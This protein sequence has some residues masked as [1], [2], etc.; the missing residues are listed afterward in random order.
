ML[1]IGMELNSAIT[2]AQIIAVVIIEIAF[3]EDVGGPL[4]ITE[5][6]RDIIVDGKTYVS[7]AILKKLT[8]PQ[9]QNSVDR[10]NYKISFNDETHVL[11]DRFAV[12]RVG[13]PVY[14]KLV[15]LNPDGS[16][17]SEALDTYKGQTSG[18]VWSDGELTV[19]LTGQLAQLN[20]KKTRYTTSESQLDLSGSSADTCMAYVGDTTADNYLEWGRK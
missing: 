3:P 9:A 17:I 1:N 15:F 11:R 20:G 14:I 19:S 2:A 12:K 4:R 7:S 10:D 13:I 5:A 6:P 16:L 8:T 18:M